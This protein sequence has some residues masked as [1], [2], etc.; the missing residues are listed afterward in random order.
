MNEKKVLEL[1][2]ERQFERVIAVCEFELNMKQENLGE[3][4]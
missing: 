4:L 1:L 3:W 2:K